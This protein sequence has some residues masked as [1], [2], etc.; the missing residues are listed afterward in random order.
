M[1]KHTPIP[2]IWFRVVDIRLF[3]PSFYPD[4]TR[5]TLSSSSR[6]AR[7]TL[8]ARC[9]APER[10]KESPSP[11]WASDPQF[12][13]LVVFVFLFAH[14]ALRA[15][16]LLRGR[17]AQREKSQ[18]SSKKSTGHASSV[19][20]QK[21]VS[22]DAPLGCPEA[23]SSSR[24]ARFRSLLQF[25]VRCGEVGDGL[26]LLASTAG[27]LG[28]SG[29]F[30]ATPETNC[31]SLPPMS[32]IRDCCHPRLLLELPPGPR[33]ENPPPQLRLEPSLPPSTSCARLPF[34]AVPS[35]LLS[36]R[37]KVLRTAALTAVIET[38]QRLP[39]WA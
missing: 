22:L 32:A 33:R 7:A 38:L 9:L 10:G 37:S 13:K 20:P 8:V 36:S 2:A 1:M 18:N 28:R 17:N 19:L 4:G 35:P 15:L 5:T 30:L 16:L 14:C 26:G 27:G 21:L 12:V 24:F 6:I 29:S 31:L 39:F 3:V 11:S 34:V 25:C 23:P